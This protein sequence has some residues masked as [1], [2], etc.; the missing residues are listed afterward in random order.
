MSGKGRKV[1]GQI[2]LYCF[3][4][5]FI[6]L[7][8]QISKIYA[9]RFLSL[10]GSVPLIKN[11]LHLT[12]IHNTGAAF[13][14]FRGHSHAFAFVAVFSILFIL[15]YFIK[16][17]HILAGAEKTALAFILGGALGNF[18]DR[19]RLGCVVDFIDFRIWP[20]FNVADSFITI[21]VTI[22]VITLIFEAKEK[23]HNVGVEG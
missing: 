11:V 23:S 4:V 13:G 1:C 6:C 20:V 14:M 21:G 17:E 2:I 9:E 22:L 5:S 18:I 12:L 16:K 15:F 19:I 7:L 3:I 10:N 8:D